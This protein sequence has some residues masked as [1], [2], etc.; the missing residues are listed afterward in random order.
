MLRI[1]AH[2]MKQAL[3]SPRFYVALL[4]GAVVQMV[5]TV[6]L[7]DF[8]QSIGEPL[9]IVDA[10]LYYNGDVFSV[11]AASLGIILLVSD[12]PFTAQSEIY[13]LLRVS[14]YRWVVGKILYILSMCIAYYA[15]MF[16]VSVLYTAGNTFFENIW[17][18][19]LYMLA[20]DD[21]GVFLVQ[22][23]VTFY[24]S[25][26][27]SEFS[28]YTAFFVSFFLSIGYAFVLSLLVFLLNLKL[29]N[30]L[31][32]LTATMFHVVNYCMLNIISTKIVQKYSLLVNSSLAYHE[33]QN[34]L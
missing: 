29:P 14:R 12:A 15:V 5:T 7:F 23:G 16:L 21:T 11:A 24:Y 34:Y 27:L 1:C 4:I 33:Y 25:Y 22:Y 6:P 26:L 28:P 10:F 17:S 9:H 32:F 18:Q 13:S 31:A 3:L 8:A 19:P 20:R 30:A 2:Q